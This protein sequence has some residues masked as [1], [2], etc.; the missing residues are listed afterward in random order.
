[1]PIQMKKYFFFIICLALIHV[2]H[3]FFSELSVFF[4]WRRCHAP[5]SHKSTHSLLP[6][7]TISGAKKETQLKPT[8]GIVAGASLL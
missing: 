2:A 5:S 7:F 8:H 3:N 6:Y 1:M 4:L